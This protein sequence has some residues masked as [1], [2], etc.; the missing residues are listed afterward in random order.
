[1]I[2]KVIDTN[3]IVFLGLFSAGGDVYVFIRTRA[4]SLAMIRTKKNDVKVKHKTFEW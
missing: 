1:M 3:L 2:E 4:I